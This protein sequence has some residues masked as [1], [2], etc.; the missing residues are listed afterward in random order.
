MA[1]GKTLPLTEFY[2]TSML[3]LLPDG[4]E[5]VSTELK[6]LSLVSISSRSE[7][8]YDDEIDTPFSEVHRVY[9]RQRIRMDQGNLPAAA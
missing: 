8:S 1:P 3:K 9:I 2:L 4:V 5:R 7:V 6:A